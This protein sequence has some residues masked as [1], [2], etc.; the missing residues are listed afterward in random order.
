M[1]Q[2]A[3]DLTNVTSGKT[4]ADSAAGNNAMRDCSAPPCAS[5]SMTT[6]T[7]IGRSQ[8]LAPDTVVEN[9]T[10]GPQDDPR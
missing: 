5:E 3:T 10:T 2:L 9:K 1:S 6:I 4:P 7:R 8:S